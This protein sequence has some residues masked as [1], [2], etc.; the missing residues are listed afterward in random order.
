[1]TWLESKLAS[2]EALEQ[3]QQSVQ[4]EV[5]PSVRLDANENWNVPLQ[6]IQGVMLGLAKRVDT[7]G[8]PTDATP[9]LCEG[10]ARQY[11]L[12]AESF[13]PCN[14]ADQAIDLLCQAFLSPG[15]LAYIVSPTFSMYRIRAAIA[16]AKCVEVSMGRGF[17]LPVD[18]IPSGG[19]GVV[20]VCSPNNP[21]GNQ[22]KRDDV[23]SLVERFGGLVVLDEAYVEFAKYSLM[24]KVVDYRN[25]VVLRTFSKAYGLAAL[26]LG[27]IAASPTWGRDFLE[28]VQY[29]YPVNSPSVEAALRLLGNP[30]VRGWVS[31]VKVERS[32]LSERLREI[33]GE[34][35]VDSESNFVL[36]DLRMRAGTMHRRLLARGVATREVGPVLQLPNCLRITV[37]TR[38][39][40][41]SRL[42]SLKAVLEDA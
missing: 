28:K 8:Y 18:E 39:M 13:V 21:T 14:G 19:E 17:S 33:A 24:D 35:V 41:R 26:R 42:T 25:L 2:M 34:M 6:K 29:P 31:K 20:F 3:Y 40:N 15:D 11:S 5:R 37:G 4:Q 38:K 1:M 36:V 23:I 22:F 9:E 30:L 32:W 16:Q 10:L 7:R 12:P 27:Y